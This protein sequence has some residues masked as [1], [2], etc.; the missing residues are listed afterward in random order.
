[1]EST[2][3]ARALDTLQS[4]QHLFRSSVDV[5]ALELS[6]RRICDI[7]GGL[8]QVISMHLSLALESLSDDQIRTIEQLIYS[9]TNSFVYS[10]TDYSLT[11]AQITQ[12][13]RRRIDIRV[14]KEGN[15]LTYI[16]NRR[17]HCISSIDGYL[18]F[19]LNKYVLSSVIIFQLIADI[20]WFTVDSRIYYIFAV[21]YRILNISIM[22]CVIASFN[23]E[24]FRL[25][26]FSFDFIVK[27]SCAVLGGVAAFLYNDHFHHTSG[28]LLM[29]RFGRLSALFNMVIVIQSVICVASL[30]CLPALSRNFKVVAGLFLS[31]VF[32]FWS[33]QYQFFIPEYEIKHPF[34]TGRT[35]SVQSEVASYDRIL[36]FFFIKLTVNAAIRLKRGRCIAITYKPYIRWTQNENIPKTMRLNSVPKLSLFP[37]PMD[38]Q[39]TM[40]STPQDSIQSNN[41]SSRPQTPQ[42]PESPESPQS[43]DIPSH[44][45]PPLS[46]LPIPLT[47]AS[48]LELYQN[49]MKLHQM[50]H[51]NEGHNTARQVLLA[52]ILTVLGGLEDVLFSV[53]QSP[54]IILSDD[55][56]NQIT[57]TICSRN[58]PSKL[59]DDDN[60]GAHSSNHKNIESKALV[61]LTFDVN[62][63]FYQWIGWR[64]P[65]FIHYKVTY[66]VLLVMEMVR[67]VLWY[68]DQRWIFYIYSL[69]TRLVLI[70]YVILMILCLN[71]TAFRLIIQHFEF[72]MKFGYSIVAAVA[73]ALHNYKFYLD[74]DTAALRMIQ[75]ISF[76]FSALVVM[77]AV[78][79]VGSLD[80]NWH[81]QTHR[82]WRILMSVS[83]TCLLLF[84]STQYEYVYEKYTI[85]LLATGGSISISSITGSSC[86]V[87][88]LFFLRQ[89]WNAYRRKHRCINCTYAPYIEWDDPTKSKLT[90]VQVACDTLEERGSKESVEE[91]TQFHDVV[92]GST[93][94]DTISEGKV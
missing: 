20:L 8:E 37:V 6:L 32:L 35:I 33:V 70:P 12:V 42:S 2:P 79:F 22:S 80:G 5:D 64:E 81:S 26:M 69:L 73:M 10:P 82:K 65:P 86:R 41:Q 67:S 55:R 13:R 51:D 83:L 54:E 14:R 38:G 59:D 1:M 40:G 50:V 9:S 60:A 66:V 57:K 21:C 28:D 58:T 93:A 25:V 4:I 17:N 53:L 19:I 94:S 44:G 36:A 61:T 15:S 34:F 16:F 52:E 7:I 18:P 92:C 31:V 72:K 88:G 23:T 30:D 24:V 87:V 68:L 27:V 3:R 77:L 45:L 56:W 47:A 11:I 84:W 75:T 85:S 74:G 76:V 71:R 89:S 62:D 63:T 48:L 78:V 39:M 91:V 90:D 29:Q 46:V 49:R 43:L